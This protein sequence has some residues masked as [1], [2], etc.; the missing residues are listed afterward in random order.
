MLSDIKNIHGL[1]KESLSGKSLDSLG[2]TTLMQIEWSLRDLQRV[3]KDQISL[4][5]EQV[6]V[7]QWALLILLASILVVT[8]LS[9]QSYEML[10]P[11]LLKSS[12]IVSILLVLSL[13]SGLNT[14]TL[15]EELFGENSAKDVLKTIGS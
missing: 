5:T 3:R 14:N 1:L 10:V 6:P 4:Y 11:S 13:I 2:N 15:F 9:I 12:F 7:L 8:V